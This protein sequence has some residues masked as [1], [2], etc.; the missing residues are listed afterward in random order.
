M[1]PKPKLNQP[2]LDDYA[3]IRIKI[4][5]GTL[6]DDTELAYML[7]QPSKIKYIVA[8]LAQARKGFDEAYN[9]AEL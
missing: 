3:V 7:Q 6:I 4:K 2:D 5:R 9:N 8:M 1:N